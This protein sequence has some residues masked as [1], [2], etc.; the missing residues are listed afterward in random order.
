MLGAANH[1]FAFIVPPFAA[2]HLIGNL[3]AIAIRVV[4][5]DTDSVAVI[6]YPLNL[7]VFL[8]DPEINLLQVL[9]ATHIPGHMV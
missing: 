4:D 7:Y 3:D 2:R 9:K 8:F 6:R 5:V 1:I